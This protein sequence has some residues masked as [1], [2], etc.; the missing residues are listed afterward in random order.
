MWIDPG[1]A[2][3]DADFCHALNA[4]LTE[5]GSLQGQYLVSLCDCTFS[6][7]LCVCVSVCQCVCQCGE[8]RISDLGFLFSSASSFSSFFLNYAD[9]MFTEYIVV[10]LQNDNTFEDL[11]EKLQVF[12]GETAHP[13]A[14]W[15]VRHKQA[16]RPAPTG[17]LPAAAAP[18]EPLLLPS[19]Q[20]SFPIFVCF[21][22]LFA[23]F[24][25]N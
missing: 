21:C 25:K 2:E 10:L 7:C 3:M 8:W 5:L 20:F 12:V 24:C 11:V 4:K 6:V 15:L 16:H 19:S 1:F 13:L 23:L 9:D 17:N 18:G 14:Q 22:P